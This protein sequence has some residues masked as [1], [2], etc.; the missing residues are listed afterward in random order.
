MERLVQQHPVGI[1]ADAAVIGPAQREAGVEIVVGSDA[2]KTLD[3]AQRVV[4]QH[5]G[6]VLDIVA[7]QNQGAGTVWAARFE[8][9]RL[10]FHSVRLVERV[11]TEDDLEIH[12]AAGL[13]MKGFG[14]QVVSHGGDV[15][16]VVAW[17]HAGE[18]ELAVAA[19]GGAIGSAAEQDFHAGQRLT[20]AGIHH[21]AGDLAGGL[22]V[23]AKGQGAAGED[24]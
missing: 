5:A 7:G 22:S 16:D 24:Q 3:G 14:H 21:R 9:A 2:G 18:A 13:Q 4:G 19:G 15:E 17:R 8:W 1:E 20:A 6:Q 23:A 10:G 12:L 11:G